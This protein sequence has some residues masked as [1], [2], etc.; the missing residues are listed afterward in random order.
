MLNVAHDK[1]LVDTQKAKA[2]VW[3][4]LV[5]LLWIVFIVALAVAPAAAIAGWRWFL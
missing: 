2:A 3:W 1:A 5:C 4:A